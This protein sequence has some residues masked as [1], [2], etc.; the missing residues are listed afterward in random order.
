MS[1]QPFEWCK[2]CDFR[3]DCIVEEKGC[4][5]VTFVMEIVLG[6]YAGVFAESANLVDTRKFLR[7]CEIIC[8]RFDLNIT[9][10]DIDRLIYQF[11]KRAV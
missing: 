7:G 8:S 4:K 10:L 3:I 6:D 5:A 2:D 9:E 1:K 11:R